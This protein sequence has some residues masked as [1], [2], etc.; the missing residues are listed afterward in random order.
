M[1]HVFTGIPLV[2][3][4]WLS[5][6]K[7]QRMATWNLTKLADRCGHVPVSCKQRRVAA[8]EMLIEMVN[9]SPFILKCIDFYLTLKYGKTLSEGLED[10]KTNINLREFIQG[11]K[12]KQVN[13]VFQTPL[14]YLASAVTV[15]DFPVIEVTRREIDI[16]HHTLSLSLYSHHIYMQVII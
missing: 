6:P 8:I 1:Y 7:F 3:E 2:I 12:A 9:N 10:A 13:V 14:D 5:H 15:N 16:W 11:I 4:G